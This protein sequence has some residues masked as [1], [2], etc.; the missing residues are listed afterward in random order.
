MI[1]EAADPRFLE[2]VS[3]A[4][5]PASAPGTACP[6]RYVFYVGGWEGRKN[7]PFLVRGFAAA[8]LD[9]VS[10]VLAGGR[11]GQRAALAAGRSRWGSATASAF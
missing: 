8:G 1:H 4:D 3:A 10:L 7:V 9:G 11:E 6:P 5:P 2:P